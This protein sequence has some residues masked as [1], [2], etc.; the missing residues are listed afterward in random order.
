MCGIVGFFTKNECNENLSTIERMMKYQ[1]HRGPDDHG[2]CGIAKADNRFELFPNDEGNYG[3]IGFNRLSIRDLSKAGHQP[4]IS[5]DGDSV[6]VFNG[7][8]YNISDIVGQYLKGEEFKGT[9]DT[10]VVLRL[11]EKYGITKTVKALNGM[12]SIVI[13]DMRRGQMY[14]VRDRIGIKPL[15]VYLDD[16]RIVFGSEIKCILASGMVHAELDYSAAHEALLYGYTFRRTLIKDVNEVTPGSVMSVDLDTL[17]IV[18]ELFW[19]PETKRNSK[20]NL[21]HTI[22]NAVK[23]Q[24]VSDVSVGSQLSGGV[25]SSIV[26]KYISEQLSSGDNRN[27]KDVAIGITMEKEDFSEEQWMDYVSEKTDINLKKYTLTG[28]YVLNNWHKAVW[29]LDGIPGFGNELGIM[30]LSEG[31][32]ENDL[33]V[34]MSG[35]GADELFAGYHN[36]IWADVLTRTYG[37]LYKIGFVRKKV[38]RMLSRKFAWV[39]YQGRIRRKYILY[40]GALDNQVVRDNCS[41]MLNERENASTRLRNNVINNLLKEK[42]LSFFEINRLYEIIVRLPALLNRQDKMTMSRS[43]ENRVPFLDNRVIDEALKYK[44][45]DLIKLDLSKVF[46]GHKASVISGKEP[47]KQ[48]SC[49][50]YGKDFTYRSKMG[51]GIDYRGYVVALIQD[52]SKIESLIVSMK[53]RGLFNMKSIENLIEKVKVCAQD[54]ILFLWR[55]FSLEM[56]CQQF[57]DRNWI[58]AE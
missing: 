19:K 4:M 17:R 16:D 57:I 8:I 9:S 36:L 46:S 40:T 42:E 45:K 26:T 15:Y 28:E 58:Q 33:T 44:K 38:G 6:I 37:M 27:I 24:L 29:H 49:G 2:I 21:Q 12:F 39:K 54:E 7:E 32:K 56:F 34:L 10:E 30:L 14:L 55:A 31:A 43:I 13:A 18:K 23:R 50:F 11:Y 41:R 48:I 52:K 3:M 1:E 25:D 53:K 51:F 35:E 47:L 20:R 22:C 5:K